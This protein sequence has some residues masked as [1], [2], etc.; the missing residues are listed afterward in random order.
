MANASIS[1][2]LTME[3]ANIFCGVNAPDDKTGSNHLRLTDVKLPGLDEQYTDLRAA[4]APVTLEINTV[5]ARLECTFTLAGWST[6]VASLVGQWGS[7]NNQFWIYGALRDR[8][9]GDVLQASAQIFGRLGRADPQ[10][11]RRGDI[12]SWA[13]TIRGISRYKLGVKEDDAPLY[14]WDYFANIF[15]VG[16]DA[17]GLGSNG[18]SINQAL[19]IA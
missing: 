16:G 12:S 9:S 5:F 13:Y 1:P 8:V 2:L 6:D 14:E 15:N 3:A 17:I 18:Q 19:N 4:G 7:Q 10:L 11:W